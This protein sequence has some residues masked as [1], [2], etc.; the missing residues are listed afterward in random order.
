MKALDAVALAVSMAVAA[1]VVLTVLVTGEGVLVAAGKLSRRRNPPDYVFTAHLKLLLLLQA[2]Y[3]Q[4]QCEC[5]SHL[6]AASDRQDGCR[7]SAGAPASYS[8][9][10]LRPSWVLPSNKSGSQT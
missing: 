2:A 9:C 5:S 1:V 7:A 10:L 8:A 3:R 4:Q 6:A